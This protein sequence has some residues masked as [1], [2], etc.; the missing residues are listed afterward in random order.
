MYDTQFTQKELIALK[1][2]KKLCLDDTNCSVII[3]VSISTHWGFISRTQDHNSD[4]DISLEE[5][6]TDNKTYVY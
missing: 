6:D 2:N 5:I 4:F 3:Q 1:P